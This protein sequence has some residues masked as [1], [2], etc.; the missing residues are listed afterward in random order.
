M[1]ELVLVNDKTDEIF[2]TVELEDKVHDD[3]LKLVDQTG[4]SLEEIILESITEGLENA[5]KS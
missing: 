1:I 3:L 4:K 5:K 2:T